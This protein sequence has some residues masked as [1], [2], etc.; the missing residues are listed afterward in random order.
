MLSF[1]A[2][3]ILESARSLWRTQIL[4]SFGAGLL[5]RG[6][7]TVRQLRFAQLASDQCDYALSVL[8]DRLR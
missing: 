2:Y 8:R 6:H 5:W 7:W 4:S 3:L 1:P